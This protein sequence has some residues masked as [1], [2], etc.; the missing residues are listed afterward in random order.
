M[1]ETFQPKPPISPAEAILIFI[2]SNYASWFT[3][4]FFDRVSAGE[5]V[6]AIITLIP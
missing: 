4:N 1:E 2:A 3:W 5:I 6:Q